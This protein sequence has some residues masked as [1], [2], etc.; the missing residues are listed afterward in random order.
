MRVLAFRLS[1]LGDILISTAFLENLP[2]GTRVDWVVASD[3]AFVLQGHPGIDRLWIF[4][5]KTGFRGWLR[6]LS[7]LNEER[8]D[9]RVDLHRTI[10]TRIAF[11]YFILSDLL[12]GLRTRAVVVSKERIRSFLLFCLKGR[13][14]GRWRPTPYW[15]RF[16]AA[17]KLLGEGRGGL[18]LPSFLP[19]L[20]RGSIDEAAVLEQYGLSAGSY[21]A[22]MPSSRWP[23]KEWGAGRFFDL[24]RVF[25]DKGW[26]PLLLGREG[27]AASLQLKRLL[28]ES[29]ADFRDALSEPDFLKTAILLKNAN[30]YVGCDTGMSHL[31]EGVGCPAVVVFG[32]TRPELGFGPCRPQSRAV[33]IPVGCAPC[34]KDGRICFRITAPNQCMRDLSLA[35]VLRAISEVLE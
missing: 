18:N 8:Y 2:R 16:A 30:F 4:D 21:F 17:G 3:F 29:G 5:R 20:E 35:P 33:S 22:M 10:R 12:S 11:A 32:P 26:I 9:V 25:Q 13:L 24:A 7:R 19:C 23:A 1:S 31:A 6:L 34:S 28:Q 15:M 14:P 27:D